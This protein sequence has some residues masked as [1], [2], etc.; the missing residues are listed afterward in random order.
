MDM[1]VKHTMEETDI[2]EYT[3]GIVGAFNSKISADR[4]KIID[5]M[6]Y[7][8]INEKPKLLPKFIWRYMLRVIV[9]IERLD[10]LNNKK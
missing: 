5:E 10:I 6:F 1:K 4:H 8:V 3:T 2:P 7:F 9:R